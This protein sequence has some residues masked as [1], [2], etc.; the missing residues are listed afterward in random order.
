MLDFS[1]TDDL[2]PLARLMGRIKAIDPGVPFI[3]AGAQARDLLL[4]HAHGIETGRQTAD[5]D[6]AF[7]V[8]SWEEFQRLRNALIGS[9]DF[10]ASPKSAHKLLF[11]GR[12]EVDLV[13]FGGIERADRTIAW[14]P[15]GDLVMSV[16]GF[17]EIANSVVTV[18]LPE[19][20]SALVVSLP[21]LAL[22]KIEAWRD[23]RLR[24]PGKDAHDLRLLLTNYLNAGNA[25][26]LH[27]EFADLLDDEAFDYEL[28]G[29]FVLGCD[30]AGLLDEGGTARILNLLREESD[31]HG[32]L[33][34]AADM[35]VDFERALALIQSLHMGFVRRAGLT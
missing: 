20:E 8:R 14:P 17:R 24:E 18:L 34:L 31:P 29:A 15:D 16:F 5:V 1:R 10:I 23:R 33:R 22:L 9:N 21:A 28:A 11:K 3:I 13:P 32:K 26:R 30:I 7:Q 2:K 19:G 6:F 25:E 35:P 27:T 4:M 12:M